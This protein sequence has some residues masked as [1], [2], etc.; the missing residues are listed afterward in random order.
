MYSWR[1]LIY[2]SLYNQL[3]TYFKIFFYLFLCRL[4]FI[5]VVLTI[6][7]GFHQ[8]FIFGFIFILF[9]LIFKLKS[10]VNPF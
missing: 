3:Y 9:L 8:F 5:K 1:I 6:R 7:D 2:R 4:S 10:D